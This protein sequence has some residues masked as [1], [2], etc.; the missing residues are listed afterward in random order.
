M[1]VCMYVCMYVCLFVC[2]YVVTDMSTWVFMNMHTNL[3]YK[4][5]RYFANATALFQCYTQIESEI[6]S[7]IKQSLDTWWCLL[8]HTPEVYLNE[9]VLF[10]VQ[11]TDKIADWTSTILQFIPSLREFFSL[12][13]YACY[14]MKRFFGSWLWYFWNQTKRH[15]SVRMAVKIF[16]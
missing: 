11:V 7:K 10:G 6:I 2:M 8:S 9:L 4:Q 1:R 15:D 16:S 12:W 5:L 14:V 3:S 13:Q